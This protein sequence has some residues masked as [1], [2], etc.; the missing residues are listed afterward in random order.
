MPWH[1]MKFRLL[2]GQRGLVVIQKLSRRRALNGRYLV[3]LPRI[4][5][6]GFA[7]TENH[8]GAHRAL[9]KNPVADTQQLLDRTCIQDVLAQPREKAS[10]EKAVRNNETCDAGLCEQINAEL[11]KHGIKADLVLRRTRKATAKICR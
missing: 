11:Y 10:Q 6:P 1:P 2:I 9:V 4:E 8:R 3:V 7:K 5:F